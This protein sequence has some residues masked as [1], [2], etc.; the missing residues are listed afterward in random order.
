MK[1]RD[2][3]PW[4]SNDEAIDRLR[5]LLE[6]EEDGADHGHNAEWL[7]G[8]TPQDDPFHARPIDQDGAFSFALGVAALTKAIYALK[9]QAAPDAIDEALNSGDGSYRP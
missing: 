6:A 3:Y 1:A 8:R 5:D 7:L 2:P 4:M 9:A